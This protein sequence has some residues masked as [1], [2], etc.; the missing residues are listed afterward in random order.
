MCLQLSN[1]NEPHGQAMPWGYLLNYVDIRK[2]CEDMKNKFI[3]ILSLSILFLFL[4]NCFAADRYYK[5]LS[6]DTGTYWLDTYSIKF[7]RNPT[8]NSI[9]ED[10]Q[11]FWQKIS[12]NQDGI[13]ETIEILKR[14]N[15]SVKGYDQLDYSLVHYLY[16]TKKNEYTIIATVDYNIY[17]EVLSSDK[18]NPDWQAIV[19]ESVDEMVL[20]LVQTYSI[21]HKR[22][23]REKS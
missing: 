6:L 15:R 18:A 19:P 16:N 10:I 14:N 8:N 21:V 7:A 3:T 23:I 2:E 20:K 13:N 11:D 5:I 1:V 4:S 22:E 17:G 12:H 9:D